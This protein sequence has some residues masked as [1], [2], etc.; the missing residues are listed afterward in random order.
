MASCCH[1]ITLVVNKKWEWLCKVKCALLLRAANVSAKP[2]VCG[3]NEL[4]PRYSPMSPFVGRI[5]V[6]ISGSN[7]LQLAPI[8]THRR[9]WWDRRN[10]TV[11]VHT[12][13]SQRPVKYVSHV[14]TRSIC[15]ARQQTVRRFF[16]SSFNWVFLKKTQ[17][18]VF[19]GFS[20]QPL[21]E[22]TS[23]NC[24]YKIKWLDGPSSRAV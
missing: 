14:E 16:L 8:R 1:R 12:Y 22:W 21:F 24:L 5:T 3:H 6:L 17:F 23:S 9:R 11:Y 10:V 13:D 19:L 15:L 7:K 18:L 20:R 4:V 2:R